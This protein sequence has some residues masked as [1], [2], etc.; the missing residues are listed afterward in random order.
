MSAGTTKQL[1]SGGS[2]L[3]NGTCSCCQYDF[4]VLTSTIYDCTCTNTLNILVRSMDSDSVS[5]PPVRFDVRLGGDFSG[6]EK[7]PEMGS[8]PCSSRTPLS[9]SVIPVFLRQ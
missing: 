6:D 2:C 8:R 4:Y 7:M 5:V 1:G 9:S 3:W